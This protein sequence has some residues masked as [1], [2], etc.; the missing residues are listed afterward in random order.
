MITSIQNPKIK[1]VRSLIQKPRARKKESVF[2][3]EGIRL[4]EEALAA[5]W[6]TS[7][8]LYDQSLNTRGLSLVRAYQ[9]QGTPVE[10]VSTDIMQSI[11]DTESPQGILIVLAKQAIQM[12]PTTDFICVLDEIRDPG[13]LGTIL[14]TAAAT[15][16]QAVFL[17]PGCTDP[18]SPKAVRA[19]MGA[20]FHLPIAPAGWEEIEGWIR[21]NGI[22][23]YLADSAKGR[24]IFA[25]DFTKPL[26]LIIGGE[27]FGA[28]PRAHALA[29][30]YVHIPLHANI[31]SF[32]VSSAAAILFYEVMRQRKFQA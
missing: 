20:H 1:W 17:T 11:S 19:G 4:A 7:L 28:G 29:D 21:Q 22:T 23:T 16:V 3:V 8:V 26:V 18:Y 25:V 15:G 9:E 32:N 6:K 14:R 24:P 2:I 12:S 5:G 30:E 13:N 27:A 31:E 10:L